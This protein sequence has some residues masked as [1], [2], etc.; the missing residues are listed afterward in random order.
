MFTSPLT[1]NEE[2]LS[3]EAAVASAKEQAL[4]L[5]FGFACRRSHNRKNGEKWSADYYCEKGRDYHPK[6]KGVRMASSGRFG[7]EFTFKIS[8]HA[9]QP[10]RIINVRST[11]NHSPTL[12]IDSHRCHRKRSASQD[13]LAIQ[14]AK[15]SRPVEAAME[16]CTRGLNIRPKDVSNLKVR[17]RQVRQGANT[18]TQQ[19]LEELD[20]AQDV[21]SFVKT[22]DG[23]D[24]LAES[25]DSP[26]SPSTLDGPITALFLAFRHG[27]ELLARFCSV[28]LIDSTYKTNRFG[29]PLVHIVGTDSLNHTFTVGYC[30]VSRETEA[31]YDWVCRCL[32]RKLGE[33]GGS[34]DIFMTDQEVALK[35]AL[36]RV[37]PRSVQLLCSW[38]V[39][40]NVLLH[41]QRKWCRRAEP[42][43]DE[44]CREGFITAF[45]NVVEA[46]SETEAE[47]RWAKLNH[48][49]CHQPQ[50]LTYLNQQWWSCKGQWVAA[51][52]KQFVHLGSRASS[53][54]EGAHAR[55]KAFLKVST[56]DLLGCV[57]KFRDAMAAEE[58]VRSTAM[59]D[60]RD[61]RLAAVRGERMLDHVCARVTPFALQRTLNQLVLAWQSTAPNPKPLGPCHGRERSRG[62]PCAHQLVS[63]IRHQ[64]KVPLSYYHRQWWFA[65]SGEQVGPPARPYENVQDPAYNP[66]TGR[67]PRAVAASS[68]R[69]D[70][71]PW[72]WRA[73]RRRGGRGGRGVGSR[74]PQSGGD[75]EE[76]AEQGAG[77]ER[78]GQVP[79]PALE[80]RPQ[81]QQ[82]AA[83]EPQPQQA[84]A[85]RIEVPESVLRARR[86]LDSLRGG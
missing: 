12:A 38:H 25:S 66:Q 33:C 64:Q 79:A 37:F 32:A 70:P 4:R 19:L 50:L 6:G 82:A 31:M 84:A 68:T 77:R 28:L 57:D 54:A 29:M 56:G 13:A 7:C 86:M 11:H 85:A 35:N 80:E 47:E 5:G 2:F 76:R 27:L 72:E 34:V 55:L 22:G 26:S 74:V 40:K 18:S 1:D 69:R 73:G 75:E 83:A 17:E 8:K 71:L 15:R 45:N 42:E 51:W 43:E 16:L 67:K 36:R 53:R 65:A 58:R 20:A 62:M 78:G 59:A 52:T 41:S 61:R 44:R 24:T 9:G 81:F 23:G 14:V 63:L 48:D 60:A 30:F 3:L 10:W 49:Y 39:Q 46:W 21:V